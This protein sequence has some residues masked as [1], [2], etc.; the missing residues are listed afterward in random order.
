[1]HTDFNNVAIK[2]IM[3]KLFLVFKTFYFSSQSII[4]ALVIV[5]HCNSPSFITFIN[6]KLK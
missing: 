1:M 4:L 3:R 2:M 5:R 6:D